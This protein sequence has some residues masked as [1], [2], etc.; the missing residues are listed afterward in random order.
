MVF[1]WL[2][3]LNMLL[4]GGATETSQN[5]PVN[6]AGHWQKHEPPAGWHWPPLRHGFGLHGFG[7]VVVKAGWFISWKFFKCQCIQ[8]YNLKYLVK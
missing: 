5:W 8:L 6:C 3:F 2:Q 1:I 7:G 4:L